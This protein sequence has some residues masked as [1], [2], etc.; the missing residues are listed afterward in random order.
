MPPCPLS[1][2]SAPRRP[3]DAGFSLAE[4]LVT[5]GLTGTLMTLAVVG[6]A[7]WAGARDHDGAAGDLV[8][9]MRQAQQ[10]A[11]TQGRA[12][13]VQFDATAETYQL[14]T[15]A[16]EAPEP[17]GA[18]TPRTLR[19]GFDVVEP[20]FL[21]GTAY[22]SGVT[23]SSRG[24]ATPGTVKIRDDRRGQVRTVAVEGL[25]GRVTTS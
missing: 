12:T 19:G 9:V 22:V 3:A 7:Q 4:V 10:Q 6:W 24:T 21:S 17:A 20:R 16:C 15:G 8:V 25:T 2:D 18:Q 14:L 1:Q 5:I 11:V 23:F 13:C